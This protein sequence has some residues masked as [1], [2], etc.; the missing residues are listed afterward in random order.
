M[1][2]L[3]LLGLALPML[4]SACSLPLS[5]EVHPAG[6]LVADPR[7]VA[8]LQVIPPGPRKDATPAET[9]LGFLGAQAD[10]DDRHGIA[11][12]FLTPSA[13]VGWH[14][15]TVVRVYDPDH[16]VVA[17]E[18]GASPSTATVQVTSL[19]SDEVRADGSYVVRPS[20]RVAETYGLRRVGGQWLLTSVPDGLRLTAAD[21]QRSFAAV[22]VYYLASQSAQHSPHLVPDRVFV[23]AGPDLAGILV[24]RLL[25]PPSQALGSSVR[26]A[27]PTGTRLRRPVTQSANGVV[28]V[29]LT[30]MPSRPRGSAAEDLSAQLV[31]TLRTLG[32]GFQQLRLLV[33]GSPLPDGEGTQDA[34]AWGAYD[35]EGL[36]P[37]PP[38]FFVS[39]R[40]LRASVDLPAGPAT[41]GE[42]GTNG[43]F[44]VD[45]VAV[46]PDRGRVALLEHGSGGDTVRVG[47]LR[48]STY[49][50]A[51][52]GSGLRSPRWGAGQLGLWLVRGERELVRVDDGVHPVPVEG[53]PPGRIRALA[54]S[55]DGVRVAL[56]VGDRLYVG[57]L[58]T[59]ADGPV[60]KAL[61]Q[62]LPALH[63]VKDVTWAAST[64]LVALGSLTRDDQVVRLAVDGSEASVLDIVGLRPTAVTAS[65]VGVLV[66]SGGRLH[67]STGGPF[68]QVQS[69]AA[70]APAYPG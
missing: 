48:G 23:P 61:T 15:D 46:T 21:R 38:Y 33:D 55:R 5:Q 65:P 68:R 39:D 57:R 51:A 2:R 3:L 47:T 19:L 58:D 7:Q 14:D 44:P 56:V 27:V 66:V 28:T 16:L 9:V 49:P 63:R 37:K 70:S 34:D 11:R 59:A 18:P 50:V 20:R 13:R 60:V 12:Q 29:D 42:P 6:D 62:P 45:E 4:V 8:P 24:A 1:K 32:S 69:D 31:W 43:A 35:P 30:G 67:L 41:V 36:G 40:R 52:H 22:P 25:R 64:E 53:L 17:Q 54:L 10:S 26:T